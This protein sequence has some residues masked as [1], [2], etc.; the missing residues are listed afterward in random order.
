MQFSKPVS[1][2]PRESK[3]DQHQNQFLPAAP[4]C[5]GGRALEAVGGSGRAAAHPACRA[6]AQ[7]RRTPSAA[8]CRVAAGR[9]REGRRHS[10]RVPNMSQLCGFW[11]TR[12]RLGCGVFSDASVRTLSRGAAS[13]CKSRGLGSLRNPDSNGSRQFAKF[14][15]HLCFVVLSPGKFMR[16]KFLPCFLLFA[17]LIFVGSCGPWS[18]RH[19]V[20]QSGF[21]SQVSGFRRFRIHRFTDAPIHQSNNP[22]IL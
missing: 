19:V 16:L 21:R 6:E 22:P 3:N 7:R 2:L 18:C 11:H 9:R 5:A 8:A 13:S 12:Q 14:A 15:D 4:G 17:A 20:S 10:F 1:K